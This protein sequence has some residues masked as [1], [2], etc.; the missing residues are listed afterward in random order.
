[1]PNKNPNRKPLYSLTFVAFHLAI[2]SPQTAKGSECAPSAAL[3]E[4]V[5]ECDSN[6]IFSREAIRCVD[7]FATKIDTESRSLT[8]R[9]ATSVSSGLLNDRSQKHSL[10]VSE[11]SFAG[12]DATFSNLIQRG[13]AAELQLNTYLQSFRLPITWPKDQPRLSPNDPE[14]VSMFKDEKCFSGNREVILASLENL[15]QMIREL[16]LAKKRNSQLEN[17]SEI[18]QR[19]LAA[20]EAQGPQERKLLMAA[21]PVPVERKRVQRSST[22]TSRKELKNDQF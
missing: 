21:A 3:F 19:R 5:F 1:M 13:K 16:E 12:S 20:R 2:N 8:K 11:H 7:Q 9:L 18:R 22:I 10:K 15:G 17:F 4:Q 6:A 14:L